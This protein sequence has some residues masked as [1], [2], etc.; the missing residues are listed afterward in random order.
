[1]DSLRLCLEFSHFWWRGSLPL[2]SSSPKSSGRPSLRFGSTSVGFVIFLSCIPP[3][4]C[5]FLDSDRHPTAGE[6]QY[7]SRIPWLHRVSS[8]LSCLF[9]WQLH[10]RAAQR[11]IL[12]AGIGRKGNAYLF[13]GTV[14]RLCGLTVLDS[15]RLG[16]GRDLN[17]TENTSTGP[18][19]Q[20]N[21]VYNGTI[22]KGKFCDWENVAD[23]LSRYC[24]NCG[25][26]NLNLAKF[27]T[28]RY[29]QTCFSV[30][31][32]YNMFLLLLRC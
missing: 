26:T 32:A 15:G 31:L 22:C 1:M 8:N 17:W 2:S 29:G 16:S 5:T 25:K 21:P 19:S 6:P 7:C 30:I 10:V 9:Q 12:G 4:D 20:V 28:I 18:W 11:P 3:P 27:S 23:K 14:D 24:Q 13:V